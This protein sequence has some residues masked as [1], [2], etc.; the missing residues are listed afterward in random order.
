MGSQMLDHRSISSLTL[1]E[2]RVLLEPMVLRNLLGADLPVLPGAGGTPLVNALSSVE[3]PPDFW[4]RHLD[5]L[6]VAFLD[7]NQASSAALARIPGLTPAHVDRLVKARPYFTMADL[8]S[9]GED[10]EE[11]AQTGSPY[12]VHH[13]YVY[14]DK[15]RGRILQLIPA[16]V[17]VIVKYIE[18]VTAVHT[19]TAVQAAGLKVRAHDTEERLLVCQWDV[20]VPERPARLRSLKEGNVAQT[21]APCLEDIWGEVRFPCP[22]RLDLALRQDTDQEEWERITD[23]YGLTPVRLYSTGYGSVRVTADPHDL[24]ALY[25]T[26]RALVKEVSVHFVEP[27]YLVLT[28]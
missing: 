15:P 20:P 12:L 17:G 3:R 13:G 8:A 10:L 9:A 11:I 21:V 16:H 25:R 5:G 28:L 4:V 22:D 23:H 27:T 24:G 26:L 7:V 6:Y 19:D 1:D 2:A 14:M 18:G